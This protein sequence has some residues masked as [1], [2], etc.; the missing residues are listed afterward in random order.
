MVDWEMK[1]HYLKKEDFHSHLSIEDI[2]H[3]MHITRMEKEFVKILKQ[4]IQI[5]IMICIVQSNTLLIGDVSENF[6]NMCQIY[7]L[8]P[9]R[10]L[11]T[12]GLAR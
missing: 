5:N 10:F 2:T 8:D 12:P 9:A 6:W 4:K 3:M 11:P 1:F 7:E